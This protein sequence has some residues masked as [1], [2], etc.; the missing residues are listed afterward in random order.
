MKLVSLRTE[1]SHQHDKFDKSFTATLGH[2]AKSINVTH[3]I[4]TYAELRQQIHEDLRRQHPEWVQPNGESPICD[5]YEARLTE[6][7]NMVTQKESDE[8]IGAPPQ[9]LEHGLDRINIAAAAV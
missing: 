1:L 8:P 5:S 7:L 3:Q 4:R 6:L 2:F 9:V